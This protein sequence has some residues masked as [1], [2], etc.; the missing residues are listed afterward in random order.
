MCKYILGGDWIDA[1][2]NTFTGGLLH[3]GEENFP[4]CINRGSLYNGRA[5]LSLS[6]Y[7]IATGADPEGHLAVHLCIFQLQI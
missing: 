1:N 7:T 4:V 5:Y 2:G 6:R 3:D